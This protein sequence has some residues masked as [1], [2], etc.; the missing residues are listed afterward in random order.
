MFEI[1]FQDP[2]DATKKAYAWQNSWG[3]S[4]RTIGAMVMIHADDNGLVLPPYVACIQ[5]VVLPVGITAKTTDEVKKNLLDKAQELVNNF[6]DADIRAELDARD[7]VSAGWKF[8]HWELKGVPVRLEVG[9]KD[10]EKNQV[11]A[12][13]RH[14]GEKRALS[15]DNL[16]EEFKKLLKEIHDAMYKK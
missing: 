10:L 16:V 11:L 13:I 6:V 7:N 2:A 9:P 1:N 4:T 3:L 5:T 8:N 15:L 14:S 12:V